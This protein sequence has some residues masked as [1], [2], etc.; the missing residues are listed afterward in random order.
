[1]AKT[2]NT[3]DAHWGTLLLIDH[4]IRKL[5]GTLSQSGYPVY[6]VVEY[7]DQSTCSACKPASILSP[8][9]PVIITI[10]RDISTYQLHALHAQ[11]L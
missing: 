10:H 4:A 11:D 7:I 9:T 1:M 6:R 8:C 2:S 3:I 5:R